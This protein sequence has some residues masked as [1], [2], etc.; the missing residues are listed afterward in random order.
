MKNNPYIYV[1][2][3]ALV[4]ILLIFFMKPEETSKV[5]NVGTDTLV[6]PAVNPANSQKPVTP[7]AVIPAKPKTS[8]YQVHVSR[9]GASVYYSPTTTVSDMI[10][11]Y[12]PPTNTIVSSPLTLSGLARGNWYFEGSAP[13]I[14]TNSKGVVLAKSFITAQSEWMNTNLVPF[15]GTLTFSPQPS[16]SS[17]VLILKRDNPSGLPTND[18]SIEILVNF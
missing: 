6:T 2:A 3:A 15:L 9:G 8:S 14:L 16:G 1:A 11:V 12:N 7:T 18:A 4:V 13:V 17:G 5:V 10:K